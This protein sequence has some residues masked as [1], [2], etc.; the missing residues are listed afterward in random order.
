[1]TTLKDRP[2]T[3]LVIIDVQNGVVEEAYQRDAI[4]ANIASVVGKARAAGVDVVWVQ[5]NGK[6]LERGT[7]KWQYVPE[8]TR[9]DSELLIEK[10][11]GDSFEDTNLELVLEDRGIGSLV[12]AGAQ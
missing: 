1:M 12:I 9:L 6:N 10:T 8:L 7:H 5:H 3:A 4:V 2:N 11:Y